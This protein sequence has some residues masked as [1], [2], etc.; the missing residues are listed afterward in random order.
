MTLTTDTTTRTLG[1]TP[2][3]EAAPPVQRAWQI[4]AAREI[5]VKLHDKNF[6]MSTFFTL[7]VIAAS[8][9]IQAFFINKPHEATIA[10]TN[11][12]GAAVVSQAE[13]A[14]AA[15]DANLE[16]TTKTVSNESAALALVRSGDADVAL[17]PAADGEGWRLV[18]DRTKDDTVAKWVG[19]AVGDQVLARHAADLG[20]T[21]DQLKAGSS[22]GYDL[23]DKDARDPGFVQVVGFIFAFLFYMAA[24]IFGMQIA[25]SVV[26]EK[27]SR[28]VEILAAAIP[29]REL[30]V[31][32]IAGNVVMAI[33]QLVLFIGV[34]MGGLALSPWSSFLV[35]VAGA[36][37]WFLVFFLVGFAVLAAM[38][39][40][41]GSLA[42]RS[43][44]LQSTAV[45][46]TTLT[47]VILF[48]GIFLTGTAQVIASY[49]PLMSVVAMPIRLASGTAVW[50]EP[51]V[52]IGITM[53]LAVVLVRI[54]ARIYSRSVMQTGSR[55]TLRQAIKLDD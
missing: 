34:G 7:V 31:G 48:G 18:S 39:A 25:Q 33:T 47:M 4:V 23:L 5:W 1:A 41:A 2:E 35:P 17:L 37:G 50:W 26:E 54:A 30:L 21:V 38:W 9:G 22:V 27:Q 3:P 46:V 49:V 29:I 28:I 36:A 55:L 40:V 14:G 20:T 11:S 19:T 24:L 10:V 52:S 6:L 12:T 32:K 15:G 13:A 43:E 51:L 42:T 53:A 44:D 45:P 8:F 16:W